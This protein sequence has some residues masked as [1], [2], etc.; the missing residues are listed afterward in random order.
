M[1]LFIL[2]ALCVYF[3]TALHSQDNVYKMDSVYKNNLQ[4][5]IQND[6]DYYFLVEACKGIITPSLQRSFE[7]REEDPLVKTW[8]QPHLRLAN[9]DNSLI[10]YYYYGI[11]SFY[12]VDTSRISPP[13]GA[14]PLVIDNKPRWMK[15][16]SIASA[17]WQYGNKT[18]DLQITKFPKIEKGGISLYYKGYTLQTTETQ[19]TEIITRATSSARIVFLSTFEKFIDVCQGFLLFLPLYNA[20]D[21]ILKS[22]TD[23]YANL[24]TT[25]IEIQNRSD[26]STIASAEI[27]EDFDPFYNYSKWS[28]RDVRFIGD[29]LRIQAYLLDNN[30]PFAPYYPKADIPDDYKLFGKEKEKFWEEA[31]SDPADKLK[32]KKVYEDGIFVGFSFW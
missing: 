11:S 29:S 24:H 26:S 3:S 12:N 9:I 17:H 4:N 2:A 30:I 14:T 5:I 27:R 32:L 16:S 21:D 18:Y 22:R 23:A 10:Y 28:S 8:D 20:T 7:Y 25:K 19:N 6:V 1:R 13:P 15:N 31:E